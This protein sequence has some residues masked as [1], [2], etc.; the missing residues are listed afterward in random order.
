MSGKAALVA[1]EFGCAWRG[2]RKTQRKTENGALS[3]GLRIY[4]LSQ[5]EGRVLIG[6]VGP[7]IR[8]FQEI[9]LYVFNLS[10]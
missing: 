3:M 5:F 6:G 2:L 7:S 9:M 4:I 10:Q 1:G 8:F